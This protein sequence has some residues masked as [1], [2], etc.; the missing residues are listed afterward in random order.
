MEA[1][2]LFRIYRMK[3]AARQQFRWAPHASGASQLKPRDFE[4]AGE[5]QAES[6]YEA[7]AKL[8]GTSQ[9][10]DI[11]DLLESEAAELRICKYVGF[12]A[13][14]WTVQEQPA[15]A[16]AAVAPVA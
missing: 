3:D 5:V 2:P 12:E 13:A 16:A 14:R 1:M 6:P 9:A 11:G 15:T 7:W 8:R 4:P 10:L